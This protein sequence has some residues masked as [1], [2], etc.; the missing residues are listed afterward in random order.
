MNMPLQ[1]LADRFKG[2]LCAEDTYGIY[3]ISVQDIEEAG[4]RFQKMAQQLSSYLEGG[5]ALTEEHIQQIAKCYRENYLLAPQC[6]EPLD[7]VFGRQLLQHAQGINLEGMEWLGKQTGFSLESLERYAR[8]QS[9]AK[10]GSVF[11]S[12]H[13]VGMGLRHT[14]GFQKSAEGRNWG[15]G[16]LGYAGAIAILDGARRALI[17]TDV[18]PADEN[19]YPQGDWKTKHHWLSGTAEAATGLGAI[20]AALKI[21]EKNIMRLK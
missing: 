12:V 16:M 14:F 15:A 7:R 13:N 2:A 9:L 17:G 6:Q 5:L 21:A 11:G 3:P 8:Q 4:V 20:A 1:E 18:T 19:G 10:A